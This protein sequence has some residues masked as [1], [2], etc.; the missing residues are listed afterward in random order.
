MKYH[1]A[2]IVLCLGLVIQTTSINA[3]RRGK[4]N[5]EAVM[6]KDEIESPVPY[7]GKDSNKF[8][9]NQNVSPPVFQEDP[10][11]YLQSLLS[12][13]KKFRNK[14]AGK[15]FNV[16]Y[17]VD[18]DGKISEHRVLNQVNS[19]VEKIVISNINQMRVIKPATLN[20]NNISYTVRFDL[21]F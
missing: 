16:M 4:Q 7:L 2:I 21:L 18:A 5:S 19:D 1:S 13:D 15:T 6:N 12:K 10:K 17:T 20:N 11:R 9:Y 8:S 3:Q 14:I